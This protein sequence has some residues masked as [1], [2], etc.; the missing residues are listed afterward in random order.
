M[1][2]ASTGIAST[3]KFFYLK[4]KFFNIKFFKGRSNSS[5]LSKNPSSYGGSGTDENDTI[6]FE[7]LTS[8]NNSEAIT[9]SNQLLQR[10]LDVD[11]TLGLPNDDVDIKD[12]FANTVK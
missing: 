10:K 4:K 9:T 12:D 11:L 1:Q 2:L 6:V 8:T 7:P 5:V 3:P